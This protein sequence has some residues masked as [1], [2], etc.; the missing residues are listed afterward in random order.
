MRKYIISYDLNSPGQKYAALA[1]GIKKLGVG[2]SW[3]CL[4]STWIIN[5]AGPTAAI[6]DNLMQF[7]DAND[8]L[9]VAPFDGAAWAAYGFQENCVAWLRN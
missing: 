1:E 5:H 9:L 2:S 3:H 6:R 7:L 4:D 8:R